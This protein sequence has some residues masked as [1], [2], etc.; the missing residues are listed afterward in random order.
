[1]EGLEDPNWV[2]EAFVVVNAVIALAIRLSKK[3]NTT[4]RNY[5]MSKPRVKKF[6]SSLTNNAPAFEFV[7]FLLDFG[8]VNDSIADEYAAF[9]FE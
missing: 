8:C 2:Q 7:G 5:N 6:I 3:V 1:M 9:P 4:T